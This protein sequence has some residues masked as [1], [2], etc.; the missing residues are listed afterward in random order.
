MNLIDHHRWLAGFL[1]VLAGFGL[2]SIAQADDTGAKVS[3]NGLRIYVTGCVNKVGAFEFPM[4]QAVTAL[5]AIILAGGPA[6][7]GDMKH[8]RILRQKADGTGQVIVVDL[9]D[10]LTNAHLEK[11]V[12]LRPND[13]VVVPEKVK[14]F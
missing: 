4:P 11:D 1:A 12:P 2:S 6:D 8:V 10:I 14:N 5:Q 13:I 7:G 9:D 3:D